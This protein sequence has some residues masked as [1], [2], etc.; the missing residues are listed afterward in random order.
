MFEV[1]ASF[2]C[3][4]KVDD[5]TL[6]GMGVVSARTFET[7][8]HLYDISD[9]KELSKILQCPGKTCKLLKYVAICRSAHHGRLSRSLLNFWRFMGRGDPNVASS[10]VHV[11][12]KVCKYGTYNTS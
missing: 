8:Q 5:R 4:T 9:E 2:W 6:R 10:L 7:N 1:G 11:S 12:H 3:C